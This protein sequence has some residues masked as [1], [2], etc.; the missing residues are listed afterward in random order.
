M[1]Y[2]WYASFCD[3]NYSAV[4]CERPNLESLPAFIYQAKYNHSP[5]PPPRIKKKGTV[6][7]KGGHTIYAWQFMCVCVCVCV[8]V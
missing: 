8:C 1:D 7:S 2:F 6:E 4:F 5:P 3:R